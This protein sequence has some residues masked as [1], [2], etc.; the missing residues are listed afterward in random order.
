MLQRG[1]FRS[2]VSKVWTRTGRW[3]ATLAIDLYPGHALVAGAIIAKAWGGP[4]GIDAWRFVLDTSPTPM[5]LPADMTVLCRRA[6]VR[7]AHRN[8]PG[9]LAADP[10]RDDDRWEARA[11]TLAWARLEIDR[12]RSRR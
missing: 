11:T 2:I 8:L 6:H 3:E 4:V 5:W 12:T 1:R 7:T 10:T 9:V